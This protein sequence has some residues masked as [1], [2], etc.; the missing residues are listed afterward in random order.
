MTKYRVIAAVGSYPY[1][2]VEIERL[3]FYQNDE[4]SAKAIGLAIATFYNGP[5]AYVKLYKITK[6]KND[7]F[8]RR[9]IVAYY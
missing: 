1:N 3:D 4:N 5:N 6:K 8:A 7:K 2:S 9:S